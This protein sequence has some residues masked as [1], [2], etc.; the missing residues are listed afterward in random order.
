MPK[1]KCLQNKPLD[2]PAVRVPRTILRWLYD[3]VAELQYAR[4]LRQE[5]VN[6]QRRWFTRSRGRITLPQVRGTNGMMRTNRHFVTVTNA[7]TGE[8][9]HLENSDVI[10][11]NFGQLCKEIRVAFGHPIRATSIRMRLTRA[12]GSNVE[13]APSA[14]V[15][16]SR[17][18]VLTVVFYL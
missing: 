13:M 16:E 18:R 17:D 12:D 1:S 3:T 14:I 10:K 15:R 8:I 6:A 9:R 4:D 5:W 7:L 11:M 2:V